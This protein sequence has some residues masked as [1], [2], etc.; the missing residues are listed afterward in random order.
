MIISDIYSV[1]P[2][3]VLLERLVE[4]LRHVFHYEQFRM[5]S[6]LLEEITSLRWYEASCFWLLNMRDILV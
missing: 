2:I 6:Y 4:E 3:T 5:F 1:Y